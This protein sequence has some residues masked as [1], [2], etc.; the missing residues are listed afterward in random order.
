MAE[1]KYLVTRSSE[2]ILMKFHRALLPHLVNFAYIPK[3]QIQIHGNPEP[4]RTRRESSPDFVL[5]QA[6]VEPTHSTDLDDDE[7]VLV[8][9]FEDNS[10][11]Q[12]L[13]NGYVFP[14]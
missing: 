9:D 1:L 6:A 12:K 11:G 4:S 7:H 8:L 3:I 13:S 14:Q 10:R 2:D 5:N